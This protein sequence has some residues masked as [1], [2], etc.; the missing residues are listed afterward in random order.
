MEQDWLSGGGRGSRSRSVWL[1]NQRHFNAESLIVCADEKMEVNLHFTPLPFCPSVS[2]FLISAISKSN[3]YLFLLSLKT[4]YNQWVKQQSN[5]W[6]PYACITRTHMGTCHLTMVSERSVGLCEVW[7]GSMMGLDMT[8]FICL[9]WFGGLG[10]ICYV[11]VS[12]KEHKLKVR[13]W[14][15]F[16]N[17][18]I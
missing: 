7:L 13:A 18:A 8:G 6:V 3:I 16:K 10:A 2:A 17:N 14:S 1:I 15:T 11:E 9:R 5:Q 12:S 4:H